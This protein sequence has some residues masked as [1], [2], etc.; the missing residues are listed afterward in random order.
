M[1]SLGLATMP[2]RTPSAWAVRAF[3]AS[4]LLLVLVPTPA[5]AVRRA[6]VVGIDIY[7]ADATKIETSSAAS[8]RAAGS[9]TNLQGATTDAEV[10][11]SLLINKFGFAEEN[12]VV[13]LDSAATRARILQELDSHLMRKSEPGDIVAF[14][15]AGHG[16]QVVNTL[17]SEQDGLD[18]SIV[19]ADSVLGADDIRDKELAIMFNKIIDTGA[20]LTVVL[21]SCHSGSGVRGL[22]KSRFMKRSNA[23]ARDG[24]TPPSP[25]KKGA[26]VLAAAQDSQLA[27]E[28]TDS[29][30]RPRGSFSL[31][32]S[33]TLLDLPATATAELVFEVTRTRMHARS[34]I[35]QE[36]VL[37]GIETRRKR[38][39][40]GD[41]LESESGVEFVGRAKGELV[42]FSAGIAS[43]LSPGT[44]L[45]STRS[46]EPHEVVIESSTLSSSRGR[47]T[48]ARKSD[49]EAVRI[50][51]VQSRPLSHPR[52]LRIYIADGSLDY[53]RTIAIGSSTQVALTS[54]HTLVSDPARE[55]RDAL[56]F[57]N[58]ST[59]TAVL[60]GGLSDPGSVTTWSSIAEL[61]QGMARQ[62][63]L[64]A[65][66][67][68]ASL[69]LPTPRNLASVAK[70]RL[71]C[72]E[73]EACKFV[74]RLEDADYA[75]V[76]RI[77]PLAEGSA[78]AAG[79]LQVAFVHR[80]HLPSSGV[81]GMPSRTDWIS[82]DSDSETEVTQVVEKIRAMLTTLNRI[83]GWLL[84]ENPGGNA[85]F[86]YSLELRDSSGNDLNSAATVRK[87]STI[88][89]FMVRPEGSAPARTRRFV[90]VFVLDSNGNSNLIFPEPD[91]G[92]VEN[93]LPLPEMSG[94]DFPVGPELEVAEP[95]GLDTFFLMST[96][97]P[98]LDLSALSWTG[99]RTR[100]PSKRSQGGLDA[101]LGAVGSTRGVKSSSV[102][103]TW[104]IQRVS[105]RTEP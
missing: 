86:G 72:G 65:T 38:P 83:H 60:S 78:S 79:K 19:P 25:E 81:L 58:G 13:L 43:G 93:L 50:Y 14:Y 16:S 82:I 98:L 85:G 70:K 24:S 104:S 1:H 20:E 56:V 63:K 71:G 59:W 22:A 97:E 41:S 2:Q 84:L 76:S 8:S 105:V 12:I 30:G 54:S 73:G 35:A 46:G 96:S 57:V 5:A 75:L 89:P 66:R 61:E 28:A 23:D 34:S 39:I 36:P 94:R 27:W 33:E 51:Q 100:G 9:W 26:L 102:P 7:E 3:F 29:A 40:F 62:A 37:S 15:Y 49:E 91:A 11:R 17:A 44:S 10:F 47:R 88:R 80:D 18:E 6:L 103:A 77:E 69:S 67:P 32:L 92:N 31:A 68:K 101:L 90:Y 95:F 74:D 21:D 55:I 87:G 48:S 42:E 64:Y 4:W 99:V 53:E 52:E 45:V